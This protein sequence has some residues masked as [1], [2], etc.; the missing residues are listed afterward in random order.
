MKIYIDYK[1]EHQRRDTST[2]ALDLANACYAPFRAI[3][4]E[5]YQTAAQI[6]NAWVS[7]NREKT[8]KRNINHIHENVH[9][10]T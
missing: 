5:A 8:I 1:D 10:L 9:A 7:I 3:R 6:S 2:E 4:N